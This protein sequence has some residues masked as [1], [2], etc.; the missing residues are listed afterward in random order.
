MAERIEAVNRVGQGGGAAEAVWYIERAIEFKG[1]HP[2]IGFAEVGD[3]F[4]LPEQEG[5][6]VEAEPEEGE[7]NAEA[8]TEAGGENG[9]FAA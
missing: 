2:D 7:G 9:S 8:E 6:E 1:E 4:L 3:D 5:E